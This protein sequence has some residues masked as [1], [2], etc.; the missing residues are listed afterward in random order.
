MKTRSDIIEGGI[1]D[2]GDLP[3]VKFNPY[4][5]PWPGNPPYLMFTTGRYVTSDNVRHF[6]A[7]TPNSGWPYNW[8]NFQ[9][10]KRWYSNPMELPGQEVSLTTDLWSPWF[11]A[12]VYNQYYAAPMRTNSRMWSLFWRTSGGTHPTVYDPEKSYTAMYDASNPVDS[13][14]VPLPADLDSMLRRAIKSMMPGIKP[15]LSLLNSFYELKDFKSLPR[16]LKRVADLGFNIVPGQTLR[17]AIRSIVGASKRQTHKGVVAGSDSYLQWQFNLAP[18]LSDVHG[19]YRALRSVEKELRKLLTDAGRTQR[20][21]FRIDVPVVYP[22]ATEHIN[23][24]EIQDFNWPWQ[25]SVCRSRVG[26]LSEQFNA[27][28]QFN[29]LIPAYQ[30]EH[31]R[32]FA[33]LDSMGV[34]LNPS[35]IWNAIPWS[36]VIDWVIGVSQFLDGFK[37]R[38]IEPVVNILNFCWSIRRDRRIDCHYDIGLYHHRL[39]YKKINL[40]SVY[41]SAYRRVVGIPKVSWFQTSGLNLKELS[42]GVALILPRWSR[43][44]TRRNRIA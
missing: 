33:L 3:W 28:M 12:D 27:E 20:R 7:I 5:K 43:R 14:F 17:Q 44:R 2:I 15:R 25:L 32:V 29:Y 40:P 21:R 37:R 34:N 18:L 31:A 13:G 6:E 24:Y 10:Y 42:L 41:E 36:F 19:L 35:I 4:D 16:T 23:Y 26:Y 8:K 9:H 39:H 38:N 22:K 30:I 11:G 1:W